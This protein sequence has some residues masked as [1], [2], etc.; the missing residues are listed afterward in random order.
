MKYTLLDYVQDILSDMDSDEVNSIDDTFESE[1]VA[2]IVRATYFALISTRNWPHTKKRI[3][4]SASGDLTKPNYMS[5]PENVKELVSIHY[6]TRK[7]GETRKRYKEMRWIENDEFLRRMSSLNSDASNTELVTDGSG[8]EIIIR[9]D[10]AP[11]VFTSFDDENLVFDSY[12]SSIDD[13]LQE[14]KVQAIA[15][16]IPDWTQQD[17]FI[18]DLPTEAVTLLLE[19]SKSRAMFKLKQMVDNKAEQES[20]K[21]SRWLSRKAWRVNGGIR[22]PNYGRKGRKGH[23][24]PT[25]LDRNN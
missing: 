14:S 10:L 25:L 9:N 11:T 24:D 13:T 3:D 5:L 7:S 15:Y 21:Q 8:I 2:R 4:L 1:Q 20:G 6:D 18:P 16:I 12:D 17:T 22:Y 19:E 23:R